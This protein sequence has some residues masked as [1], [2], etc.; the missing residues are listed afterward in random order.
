MVPHPSHRVTA[1][2]QRAGGKGINVASVLTRMGHAVDRHR[3]APGAGPARDLA[4]IST[5]GGSPTGSWT[6]RRTPAVRSRSSRRRRRR[7]RLQRAGPGGAGPGWASLVRLV[8]D[9]VREQ[10][11]RRRGAVRQPAARAAGRRLRRA[12]RRRPRPRRP[13]HR[14]R[15]RRGAAR[16]PHGRRPISSS[17]TVP[18][19]SSATGC[20]D[21]AAGGGRAARPRRPRR[22]GLRRRRRAPGV[23]A[24]AGARCSARLP[25]PL[26]GN[27]T[28]AGDALVAALA[29]GLARRASLA[30][31]WRRT[32]WP[33]RPPRCC[34]RWPA[35]STPTTWRGLQ[36]Q[37]LME[38][39]D[40]PRP[41]RRGARGRRRRAGGASAPST[42]SSS[43]TPRRSSRPPR[44]PAC[45]WCCRS[46]R[47]PCAT[48]V[49]WRRSRWPPRPSPSGP[50]VPCVLHL[51]HA[52][53]EALVD[54]A[55]ALGLH[56]GD[57]RRVPARR[58]DQP[59]AR[60]GRSSQRCHAA[61]RQ[62][63]GRARRD[64]R[65]GRRA[66][67]RACAPTRPRRRAFV[68]DTG[69]DA[70]AVAVG[71]SHAMTSRTAELDLDLVGRD[72]RG[73]AGAAGAARLLRG[74]GRRPRRRGRAGMTKVNIA[75]HLNTV[76]TTARCRDHLASRPGRGGHPQVPRRRTCGR[77]GRDDPADEHA[78]PP[79]RT[80]VSAGWGGV[81]PKGVVTGRERLLSCP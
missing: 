19:C 2:R 28:G 78:R 27:P 18:S 59:R 77:G 58:R 38:E 40:D 30:G 24:R 11:R 56:L 53:S 15:R 4:P 35:R 64:R 63:R 71:S 29:A 54:E 74:A 8:G 17:P 66:R 5:R 32:R 21:V 1:V 76:F 33:G 31:G 36:A 70:L 55:V 80:E 69:V 57:V 20:T 22:G 68:A 12:G 39:P 60:P 37:V 51:D 61:R 23:P 44:R 34:S 13:G 52:V 43:S 46:A 25:E 62:R 49:R 73:G 67:A 10:R 50:T 7:H 75:T 16:R 14:R 81:R 26:A 47:T 42:S 9:L 3:V 72:P 65:Q 41:A 45:R 79:L 48:T 6:A